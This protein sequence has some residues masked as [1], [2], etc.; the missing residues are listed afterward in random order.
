MILTPDGP[1]T[2][3]VFLL[4]SEAGWGEDEAALAA[5]LRHANAVVVGIDLPAY[6]AALDAQG[7]D[8][9]YLVADFERL[10]HASAPSAAA[11]PVA[12]APCRR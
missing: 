3:T 2:G 4:S 6:L 9:V 10:S 1:A 7:Q 8:C 11:T 5:R 12:N